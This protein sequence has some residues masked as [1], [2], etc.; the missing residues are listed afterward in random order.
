MTQSSAKLYAWRITIV[1]LTILIF[2]TSAT[3]AFA[4]QAKPIREKVGAYTLTT[5]EFTSKL[6]GTIP[7]GPLL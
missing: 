4:P 6:A 7:L 5:L 1:C 3:I 2:G